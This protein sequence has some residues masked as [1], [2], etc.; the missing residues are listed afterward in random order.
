MSFKCNA[1]THQEEMGNGAIFDSCNK[2]WL[3]GKIKEEF[4]FNHQS[5]WGNYY[6]TTL[7]VERESLV[8]DEI[9]VIISEKLLKGINQDGWKGKYLEMGG[10]F[11]SHDRYADDGRHLELYAYPKKVSVYNEASEFQEKETNIVFLQGYICKEP[12]FRET[13]L[14]R[15]IT[16]VMIVVN[17]GAF[18]NYIPC[19]MWGNQA[20]C[21]SKLH[22]GEYIK[23]IG[24]IQSRDYPKRDPLDETKINYKTVY[25]VSSYQFWQVS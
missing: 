22:V 25:E 8:V 4:V 5:K 14:G 7:A 15:F 9:P 21:I 13:P 16:D 3:G 17:Q 11:R 2:V 24:R 12:V 18:S 6:R 1:I 19:I 20:K 23:L 10:E